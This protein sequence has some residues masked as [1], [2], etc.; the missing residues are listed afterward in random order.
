MGQ[1]EIII[2]RSVAY[3]IAKISW[4]IESKGM[5]GTAEKYADSIYA[6]LE[7]LVHYKK[8]YPNCRDNK[9]A[10]LGYKCISFRKKTHYRICRNRH[11]SHYS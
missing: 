8:S 7:R 3:S 6:F 10:L 11:R 1:R 4:F 5:A 9:R 2:K